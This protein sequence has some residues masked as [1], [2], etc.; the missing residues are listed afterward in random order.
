[1]EQANLFIQNPLLLQDQS[2]HGACTYACGCTNV[3]NFSETQPTAT[4]PVSLA[5]N[6]S[7][8][9]T[10]Q[11]PDVH[12][13]KVE[14]IDLSFSQTEMNLCRNPRWLRNRCTKWLICLFLK[15]K[16][17][18]CRNPRRFTKH[19]SSDDRTSDSDAVK[20]MAP[21][22]QW[23]KLS[24]VFTPVLDSYIFWE[25]DH[26]LVIFQRFSDNQNNMSGKTRLR[27]YI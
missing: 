10:C 21:N 8:E 17:K 14:I 4:A 12:D 1:M 11:P 24:F 5:M 7:T 18:L 3:R 19:E 6:H 27:S 20:V 23:P 15:T 22:F 26:N 16:T 25:G 9:R 2:M 13:F